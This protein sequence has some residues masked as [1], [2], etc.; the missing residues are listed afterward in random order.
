MC[1]LQLIFLKHL[2]GDVRTCVQYKA[3]PIKI[4]LRFVSSTEFFP[5]AQVVS[6]RKGNCLLSFS[7]PK[8][9][10]TCLLLKGL[11]SKTTKPMD[12]SKKVEQ[13]KLCCLQAL[14]QKI[15]TKSRTE[16]VIQQPLLK[17]TE[18]VFSIPKLSPISI[19]PLNQ[20]WAQCYFQFMFSIK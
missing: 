4:P 3:Q 13:S 19:F 2:E 17:E 18:C 16:I 11:P 20:T 9:F 12:G 15:S 8:L 1:D 10:C 7:F 14:S 6:R 5:L